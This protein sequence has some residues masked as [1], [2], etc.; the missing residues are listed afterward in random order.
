MNAPIIIRNISKWAKLRNLY[1][2]GDRGHTNLCAISV[3]E[4]ALK[5]EKHSVEFE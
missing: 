5:L 4:K 3:L 1:P 2:L